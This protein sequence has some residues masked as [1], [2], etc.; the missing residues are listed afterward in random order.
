MMLRIRERKR[1]T[2]RERE[3]KRDGEKEIKLDNDIR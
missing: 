3:S 2:E 1:D